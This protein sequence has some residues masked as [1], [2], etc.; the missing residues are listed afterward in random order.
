MNDDVDAWADALR[1]RFGDPYEV[2]SSKHFVVV[3]GRP[4]REGDVLVTAMERAIKRIAEQLPGIARVRPSPKYVAILFGDHD[5]F[6]E[7]ASAFFPEEGEFG[8]P[9]GLYI[10]DGHGHFILPADRIAE[11][12]TS[13]THEL[14]HALTGHLD[15]PSWIAEGLAESMEFA[16]GFRPPRM[17]DC[18]HIDEHR[19]FWNEKTLRDFWSGKSFKSI[20]GQRLSYSLAEFLLN[21]LP[22]EPED[23]AQFVNRATWKDSGH[24][25]AREILGVELADLIA[26]LVPTLARR[27]EASEEDRPE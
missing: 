14:T 17:F 6:L 26:P 24:S 2:I 3:S 8:H 10:H 16:A 21:A 15:S 12:E 23:L 5:T 20:E 9:G 27:F 11:L 1:D 7:Y 13:I 4:Q 25:A 18:E 22:G 19:K